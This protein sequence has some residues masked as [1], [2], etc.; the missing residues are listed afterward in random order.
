M[1]RNVG[2]GE[3]RR[4]WLSAAGA[5]AVLVGLLQGPSSVY[6][7]ANPIRPPASHSTAAVKLPPSS[8]EPAPTQPKPVKIGERPDLR[9]R[10]SSTRLNQQCT[11]KCFAIWKRSLTRPGFHLS[12]NSILE[13]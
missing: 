5:C 8:G 6:A 9:G 13:R 3:K 2:S 11:I 7:A 12:P 1:R 4:L 10:F